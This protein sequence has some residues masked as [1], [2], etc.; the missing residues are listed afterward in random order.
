[1]KRGAI[2]H[3][4]PLFLSYFLGQNIGLFIWPII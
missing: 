4:P 3:N 1:M 2:F